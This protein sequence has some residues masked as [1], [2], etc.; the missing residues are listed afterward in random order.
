MK[1]FSIIAET[2]FNHMGSVTFLKKLITL[3]ESK[4]IKNF[5]FQILNPESLSTTDYSKYKFS[6]LVEISYQDWEDFYTYCIEKSVEFIPCFLDEKSFDSLKHL[7]FN[8]IKVHSTDLF[9]RAL[10]QKIIKYNPKAVLLETQCTNLHEIDVA[11]Q[12]FKSYTG[13][14]IFFHGFSDYPTSLEDQNLNMISFLK[15]RYKTRVGFA[16]HTLSTDCIPLMAFA[17]G[18]NIIEKHI[19]LV[20]NEKDFDYQVSLELDEFELLKNNI[21]K[22]KI[23]LGEKVKFPVENE[24]KYKNLIHKKPM[25]Q[26]N[27]K[28]GEIVLEQ[29]LK[30]IRSDFGIPAGYFGCYLNKQSNRDLLKGTMIQPE[31]HFDRQKVVIALIARLKSTRLKDKVI[32]KIDDKYMI[33]IL[34][35]RLKK[36]NNVEKIVLATS[37]LD[38]DYPLVEICKNNGIDVYLGDPLNVLD[39]LVNIGEKYNADAVIRVT[40]DN[41]LTDYKLTSKIIE[42]FLENP[43]LDFMRCNDLPLGLVPEIL[44]MKCL[45]QLYDT[46]GNPNKSEYLT[47]YANRPEIFHIGII[48]LIEKFHIINNRLSIDTPEDFKYLLMLKDWCKPE[49]LESVDLNDIIGF[50]VNNPVSSDEI[51]NKEFKL[52]DGRTT[53]FKKFS[54]EQ[55]DKELKSKI[56][57][58][59]Y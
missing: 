49:T 13:E 48:K 38:E 1:D 24:Y 17:K 9:N 11:F 31:I 47:L 35:S 10:I 40:G 15:D 18:A 36:I 20:R 39:R 22:Y 2:A 44:S 53:T 54:D 19:T 46:M 16:D 43:D 27:I 14:I 59:K 6:K 41:V 7:E 58:V 21:E 34:I 32:K 50:M 33:E 26:K 45:Y 4:G 42:L 3:A 51:L 30:I 25:L 55:K 12:N 56:F 5:S 37:H 57:N 28:A 23:A 8:Y 29:D 52:P